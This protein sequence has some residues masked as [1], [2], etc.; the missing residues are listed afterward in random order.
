MNDE[1]IKE[2]INIFVPEE[3]NKIKDVLSK[4]IFAYE[5]MIENEEP[6]PIKVDSNEIK[7]IFLIEG[8]ISRVDK[9]Y[10]TYNVKWTET[11]QYVLDFGQKDD[12]L[13]HSSVETLKRVFEIIKKKIQ[14]VSESKLILT[15]KK[16][17]LII[18]YLR[19]DGTQSSVSFKT[20]S[21]NTILLES[22]RLKP[23]QSLEAL[24]SQIK[25][26]KSNADF[27]SDKKRVLDVIAYIRKQLKIS[28]NSS[29]DIFSI[30]NKECELI[31]P[32]Q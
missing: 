2:L 11:H 31:V 23:K 13:P 5:N 8:L 9:Y 25:G 15:Y 21:N 10:Y 26:A 4:M 22:L 16:G 1:E 17:F 24:G 18:K 3:L 6:F 7:T 29:D 19:K 12:W 20:T 27:P 14:D 28:A 32:I 30:A